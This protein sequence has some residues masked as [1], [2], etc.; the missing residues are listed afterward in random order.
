M[1]KNNEQLHSF[2]IMFSLTTTITIILNYYSC[3]SLL[4]FLTI[5]TVIHSIREFILMQKNTS[6]ILYY[7]ILYENIYLSINKECVVIMILFTLIHR[8]K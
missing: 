3:D 7:I 4:L 8:Q 2:I 6:I 5:I 1:L